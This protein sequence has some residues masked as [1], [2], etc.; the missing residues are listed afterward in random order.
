MGIHRYY[1]PLGLAYLAA[2]IERDGHDV[3]VYDAEHDM[4]LRPMTWLESTANYA[5]YVEALENNAHPVW[6]EYTAVLDD[7]RPQIVGISALSVKAEAA[8]KMAKLCKQY[9]EKIVVV[10]GADHPSAWPEEFLAHEEVDFVVRGEGEATFSELL[11]YLESGEVAA[12]SVNG[13]SYKGV[14]RIQ[15][16]ENRLP[17]QN[18]DEIPFPAVRNLMDIDHYRPVDLGVI[19]TSRGCPYRCRF[20]G[21]TTLWGTTIRFR[22]AGNVIAEIRHL[23]EKYGTRYFS[24][25]DASFTLKRRRI[26]NLC[27]KLVEEKLDIQWECLTR[28]N[29]LDDELVE[30][31]KAAGCRL[32]RVGVESGSQA[33]LDYLDKGTTLEEMRTAASLLRRHNVRWSAY[34]MLGVPIETRETLAESVEFMKELSPDFISLARFS[35]IPGT[36]LYAELAA[37]GRLSNEFDWRWESNQSLESC[38]VRD[39]PVEE[40]RHRM[41]EIGAFVDTYNQSRGKPDWRSL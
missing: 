39:M 18:L 26:L 21:I 40:F 3:K 28:G 2:V 11:R 22:S 30:A 29:L 33:I 6:S 15:H 19:I 17:I 9:D 5:A 34:F 1:Y 10:V 8:L 20:C 32:V 24:F 36:E 38:F 7:F 31:M 35:P 13:L 23:H 14:A 16:N 4:A 27:Q 37:E 25:R 12:T 41:A